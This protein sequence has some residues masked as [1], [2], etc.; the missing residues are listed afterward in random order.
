MHLYL[1]ED[2]N[3]WGVNIPPGFPIELHG[4]GWEIEDHDDLTLIED[5]IRAMRS[6]MRAHGQQD[7][8]LW[9]SEYGILMPEDYGFPPERV[10]AFLENSFDLFVGLQDPTLGYPPDDYRLVQRWV[11]YPVRD[12]RYR[13][14]NLFDDWGEITPVGEALRDYLA[15]HDP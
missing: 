5:Q 6:W 13:T 7:K 14:G 12:S 8:P 3:T 2:R 15:A 1:R 10:T 4:A 11:W 9:I